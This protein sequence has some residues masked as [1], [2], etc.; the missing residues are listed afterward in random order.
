MDENR[1]YLGAKSWNEQ[2]IEIRKFFSKK[3]F[4]GK[5]KAYLIDSMQ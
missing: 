3:L 1:R 4:K 5:L 2:P